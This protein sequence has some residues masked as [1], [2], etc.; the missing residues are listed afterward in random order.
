MS[1]ETIQEAQDFLTMISEDRV[2]RIVDIEPLLARHP[3]E[4]VLSM[5]ESLYSEKK[6]V[7][8]KLIQEDK[9]SSKINELIVAMFRIHMAMKTIEGDEGKEVKAA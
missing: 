8:A 2:K 6:D 7:L 4:S 3:K 9:T 5:L 1:R